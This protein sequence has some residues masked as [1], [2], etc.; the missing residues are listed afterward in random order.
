[1][2]SASYKRNAVSI[3]IRLEYAG[4]SIL[5][6][7]DAVG[8]EVDGPV[9]LRDCIA[10]EKFVVDNAAQVPI[11]SDVLIAPHHGANNASSDCFIDEVDPEYVIFSAGHA[12]HHPREKTAQRYI[13]NGV[14]VSNMFRTDL[15]DNE[16]DTEWSHGAAGG[17]GPGDDH[18]EII[19]NQAGNIEVR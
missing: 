12:H 7:G 15:G 11:E 18:V 5:F 9:L 16:G 14:S 17:D 2:P 1:M 19:I 10:T 4:K 8:R 6:A 13:D 3:I